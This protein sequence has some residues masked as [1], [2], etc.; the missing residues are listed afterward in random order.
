M[1]LLCYV[2]SSYIISINDNAHVLY[3]RTY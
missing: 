3:I 2:Y 1:S